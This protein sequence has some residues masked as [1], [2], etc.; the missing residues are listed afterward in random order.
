MVLIGAVFSFCLIAVPY[1]AFHKEIYLIPYI[2]DQFALSSLSVEVGW[3]GFEFMIGFLYAIALISF[4]ILLY[5]RKIQIAIIVLMLGLGS[6]MLMLSKYVVP[7][8]E[9]YS[10]GPA[11]EFYDKI[12]NEDKYVVTVGYKVMPIIFMEKPKI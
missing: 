6:T 9:M 8:I 10:Q 3:N 4:I 7:K 2:K 11:I 12:K 1:A 5:K